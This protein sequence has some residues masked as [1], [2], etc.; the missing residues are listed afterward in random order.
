MGSSPLVVHELQ[1]FL[2]NVVFW[3]QLYS[4]SEL[5]FKCH[6]EEEPVDIVLLAIV[7]LYLA[8]EVCGCRD[9]SWCLSLSLPG[10]CSLNSC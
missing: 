6:R 1:S 7:E 4:D 3:G 9:A 8:E 5:D 10:A 2:V